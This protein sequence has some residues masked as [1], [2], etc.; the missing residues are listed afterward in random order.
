MS[1][2]EH[3]DFTALHFYIFSN[4]EVIGYIKENLVGEWRHR[5]NKYRSRSSDGGRETLS[6]SYK[7]TNDN[8]EEEIEKFLDSPP[9]AS[10]LKV[11]Q[12]LNIQTRLSI[13]AFLSKDRRD[14]TIS[15]DKSL[16]QKIQLSGAELVLDFSLMD[17]G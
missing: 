13:L 3:R 1:N 14:I 15:V 9:V 12:E 10:A 5:E 16:L 2:E 6:T 4:S 7:S 11:T 8:I 17:W